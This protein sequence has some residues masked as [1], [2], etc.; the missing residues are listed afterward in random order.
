V[1]H[2]SRLLAAILGLVPV[3]LLS[4]F[5][6]PLAAD[7]SSSDI[8]RDSNPSQLAHWDFDEAGSR[9]PIRESAGRQRL[10]CQVPTPR[11]HGVF[12]RC[13]RLAGA[14]RLAVQPIATSSSLPSITFSAWVRPEML[15]GFREI[16]RQECPE[17][18]LFSF[19]MNGT[20]LSLG[21][22]INGYVE[23]DA[24]I[25]PAAVLDG[26]WHHVAATHDGHSMR[27]YL[28][29]RQI[30]ALDR[31]GQITVNPTVPAFLASSG[32]T[33]EHFQGDLDELEI[34]S[35]AIS[36]AEVNAMY[37]RGVK[38]IAIRAEELH[39]QLGEIY[40][41]R[42]TF[43]QT[44]AETANNIARSKI[45]VERDLI[46]LLL[47][48]LKAGFPAD[49]EEFVNRVGTNPLEFFASSDGSFLQREAARLMELLVE[50]RPLTE[51]QWR[52]QSAAERKHWETVDSIVD[53]YERLKQHASEPANAAEWIDV[54]LLAG[55]HIDFRPRVSEAVAPYRT[56]A[57]PPTRSLSESESQE[58]L[59]RD[60]LHQA[61]GKPT[62]ANVQSEIHWTRQ[63]ATRLSRQLDNASVFAEWLAELDRLA[64]ACTDHPDRVQETYFEVRRI[65]REI[66]FSNPALDFSRLL[67]VDMPYPDG[68]E[69]RHETRHRLGYMAV[70]G[71]RLLVLDGLGPNG[72]LRQLMP[73]AP[74][75]GS[76]WR[77]DIS[78]DANKVLVSFKP[79]NEKS[80]H[81]YEINVDG[82]ELVQL[83]DGPY[84]DLDPIYLP[85]EEHIL[86]STTRGN[87]YVRCMPPT[88]AYVLAR[89]RR[90]GSNIYLIS[91]NNEPDYLPSLMPDGRVIYTRWEYT[92]KP[93]WRAQ[94]LWTCNPDGTQVTTV[95]GNQSVWPD[96]LKDARAIPGSH[97][98]MFT[99]SAHHDWFAGS[100]GIVDPDK[101]FNFPNGLTKVTADMEWPECGNGPTDPV[102]SG[103]YHPSGNYSGYYSPFPL[104]E[105]D[106]LV[107]ACRDGKFVLY[108]MDVD[109][110]REL[111]YEGVHNILHA[112]PIRPRTRPP[113]LVD[114][115]NWPSR[116]QRST[117]QKGIIYSADI[118]HGAPE[119]LRG[120]G[121][122]LRVVNIEPKTYT[123]WHKRP[124]LSTGPVV[125]AVQSE[126]VKRVLGTVPIEKDGSL[127]F[128]APSG[129][130]LHFQVLDE[131]YR[132]LQT[133]RSFTGV[134]PGERRGCLG[135]HES[136]STTPHYS[137]PTIASTRP[138]S[139]I[140]PPPWGD[141]SVSY[142]RFVRPS[143]TKYCGEC[144]EGNG[145]ATDIL[146]LS[147]RPGFLFFDE[148][149][150]I[151]TGRPSWG[152]PY[153]QP[154]TPSP[155]F[156]IANMIMVEGYDQ[157]D[158]AAYKTVEPMTYLSFRSRLV[159]IA[160]SGDH[161]DVR[162]DPTDLR[163]L[164]AWIDTMCPYR[165]DQEVR[166]LP[167][168]DFQGIDWLSVRPRIKTAPTVVRPGPVD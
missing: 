5:A 25:N 161:Y 34:L 38:S 31:P 80:F 148:A 61:N 155:G 56:P 136:H 151:L 159:E 94:G 8:V 139:E 157:R 122:Y 114:R 130:A 49:Y 113:V 26:A 13:L 97:R 98:I 65:K 128:S 104:N 21:L 43:S 85:D 150:L 72:K 81:I 152:A 143:L 74:L 154:N 102:E 58:V 123:Y 19:Q 156:G 10:D 121:R 89:A 44:L 66:M 67:F 45:P 71:A 99:G 42:D 165:G 119:S 120:R 108:L 18:L 125:S 69:W 166:A 129:M 146:N 160:S 63:L 164:I 20:I 16:Y 79:H 59:Q 32:G 107:S 96:L 132:A 88:N 2:L 54:V 144:H 47:T 142:D 52:N 35:T 167:D 168:P 91:R 83:T 27:V 86:F 138:P 109:G 46:G 17:R 127:A 110:N 22:N 149:Y 60:W 9:P 163:K 162:L 51:Q 1:R 137:V 115:V 48:R 77:P 106:F 93:L 73:Q 134:M 111:I 117:P 12:G 76:F 153:Q 145:E 131:N 95:W 57:T 41:S 135:C 55:R 126:G 40:V 29:G 84:D 15:G 7:E 140:T 68:S 92:D 33:S 39:D 133:M 141:E 118:Y 11:E 53:R 14:H 78:F 100:V 90:D 158:P 4:D 116:Q 37:Q 103:D 82:T 75:H 62:L 70:P 147:P 64:A 3:V 30:G 6:G 24:P 36:A 101:G 105:H 112:I 87:T 28:D 23:C 50:Y 124:Y